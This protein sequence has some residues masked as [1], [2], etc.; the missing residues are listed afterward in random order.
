MNPAQIE[1]AGSILQETA[2][3]CKITLL[4]AKASSQASNG[5]VSTDKRW[6]G[7][8]WLEYH[9]ANL[10]T[11]A[12]ISPDCHVNNVMYNR[13]AESAR[14]N[15]TLNFAAMDPQHKAEWM[16]LMTPKSVGLILRSIKTDYKFLRDNPSE[17]SDHFILDVMILSEAQRRPAAR[18]VEDIVTYDY[19]TAKKSPLPPFMIKKLQETF[20]LQEEAKEKN[21]NRVRVLL[22][23]VRELEKSSWD[24]PDA[25]ED[26]GSANQ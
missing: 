3:D 2:V 9:P 14:V 11:P 23:R 6:Y 25:K 17:N 26:F 13:Y 7:E 22:D 15:W 18:C 5:E 8:K 4:E 1:E 20:K 16:E 24:R 12:N 19:R 10:C 21:S